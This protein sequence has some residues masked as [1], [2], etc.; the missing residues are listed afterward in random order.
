MELTLP[1]LPLSTC[2]SRA[3]D[4]TGYCARLP[5]RRRLRGRSFGFAINEEL[6]RCYPDSCFIIQTRNKFNGRDVQQ[7]MSG[8]EF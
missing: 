4:I 3:F 6:L 7:L 8:L 5:R 2:N 1:L